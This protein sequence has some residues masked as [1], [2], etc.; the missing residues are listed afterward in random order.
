M[1]FRAKRGISFFASGG[2]SLWPLLLPLLLGAALR[3]Y[4]LGDLPHGIYHDEAFYGLDAVSVTQ[5]AHPIFFTANNGREP[6]YIYILSLSLAVFGRTPFGLRLP[7]AFIGTATIAATYALGRSLF[8]R[9]IGLLAAWVCTFT[10]WPL[11][12]SRISFRAGLLPLLLGLA[13]AWGLRSLTAK[14]HALRLAL[15]GGL[16]YGLTFNTYTAARVTPLALMAF[17]S[18]QFLAR[19]SWRDAVNSFTIKVAGV[20]LITTAIL[21]TPLGLYAL[22]NPSQVFAREEQVSI[23][24]TDSGNPILV[25]AKHT[26][27]ALAMFNFQGDAIARHNIPGRPV[28]DPLMSIFF[29]L[30]LMLLVRSLWRQSGREAAV[31]IFLWLAVTLLP[32]IFAEDTPH[33]LRSIAM[34]PV[35]WL[36]PAVGLEWLLHQKNLTGFREAS[37]S[38]AEW[39]KPV[40][41]ILVAGTIV[42][43][44]L[45]TTYDY[46]ARYTQL[47]I[48][49]YYFESAATD[50]AAQINSRPDFSNRIDNRLWDNFASL[51]FLITNRAGAPSP[52]KVQLAVWPYEPQA[53]QQAVAALPTG[54]EISAQVGP[55][56]RG[57]LETTP[58]SL[59]TLYRTQP[60]QAEPVT[61]HFGDSLE[62]RAAS[63]SVQ[64]GQVRVRLGWSLLQPVD[65][66]YHV[67]VHILTGS[68][69][70]AQWDGEPLQNQYHFSWLKPGDILNDTYLL[71]DGD[72]VVVGVYAPDGTPLGEAVTLK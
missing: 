3:F 56:A 13:I 15:M 12:L 29:L 63:V 21:V 20:F 57:D 53:V 17:T 28:F 67:F 9:H 71:P 50:L 37:W 8:N 69:L 44:A 55:L 61:A 1:S 11:A 19:R 47:P 65:V 40:R 14:R 26:G 36:V 66:D 34:Q 54:S 41:F 16:A 70:T 7:S 68:D 33:Y 51:R 39:V 45:W 32:T 59:Y 58:Y 2:G 25:L 60:A 24:Q 27:L 22:A 5:G 48:T 49:H 18:W 52:T 62:L 6:F 46:F 4:A 30:G 43:S 10:F 42:L 72:Q 64:G 35:L 23:F 31:F 38:E